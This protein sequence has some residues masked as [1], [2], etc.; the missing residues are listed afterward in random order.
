MH[1][2]KYV[3]TRNGD[4]SAVGRPEE[5]RKRRRSSI[6]WLRGP[7]QKAGR[8]GHINWGRQT[9][10]RIYALVGV[11]WVDQQKETKMARERPGGRDE[12]LDLDVYVPLVRR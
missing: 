6:D 4:P 8:H 2:R 3:Q 7:G 12:S 10:C 9:L 11:S 5:Y 1:P